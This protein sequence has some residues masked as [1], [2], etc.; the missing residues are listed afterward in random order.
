[1]TNYTEILEKNIIVDNVEKKLIVVG[2]Q[3]EIEDPAG[4]FCYPEN[5]KSIKGWIIN[6]RLV[7]DEKD[8]QAAYELM[9][10]AKNAEIEFIDGP[11]EYIWLIDSVDITDDFCQYAWM[12]ADHTINSLQETIDEMIECGCSFYYCE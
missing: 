1:M 9:E 4:Y 8:V 3:H 7:N 12:E 6:A 2:I 10:K 11:Y 5:V